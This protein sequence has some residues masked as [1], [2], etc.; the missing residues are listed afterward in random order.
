MLSAI[1]SRGGPGLP[2]WRLLLVCRWNDGQLEIFRACTGR[3][4]APIAAFQFVWLVIDRRG[5]KSFVMAIIAVFLAAFRDWRR[6]LS[7]GERAVVL[8]VAADREQAKILIRY[9]QGILAT[10]LLASLVENVT[11]DSV[12][13]KGSVTV[14]VVTRSYRSV[15]SRSRAA[16]GP[17]C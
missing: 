5:G 9:I 14:E 13:L 15:A 2:S 11:A 16:S 4:V 8:L 12:D 7:P 1:L 17:I 3:A 10:P 6:F